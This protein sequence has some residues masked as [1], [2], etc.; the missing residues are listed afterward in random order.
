MNRL[1]E[2]FA[3]YCQIVED[4]GPYEEILIPIIKYSYDDNGSCYLR[5]GSKPNISC[6]LAGNVT[7][8]IRPEMPLD[9]SRIGQVIVRVPVT[10]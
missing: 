4:D 2:A 6:G 3:R 5:I 8:A 7:L 9:K 10:K 1:D